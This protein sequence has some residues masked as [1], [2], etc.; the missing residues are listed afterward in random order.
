MKPFITLISIA[1]LALPLCAIAQDMP[2]TTTKVLAVPGSSQ[3]QDSPLVR[4]AKASGR[5]N[6]KPGIVI[7]NETLARSGGHFAIADATTENPQ[8]KNQ[9]NAATTKAQQSNNSP[10]DYYRKIAPPVAAQIAQPTNGQITRISTSQL[11]QLPTTQLNQA[12][13]T[14]LSQGSTVQYDRTSTTQLNQA[15]TTQLETANTNRPPER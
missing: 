10:A 3:P 13:T 9:R 14:Q 5:L 15:T 2:N 4:A 6:K 7:T 12:S 1:A 8:A 11:N